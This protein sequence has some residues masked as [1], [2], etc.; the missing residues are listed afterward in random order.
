M[1]RK[2]S[3][4][5]SVLLLSMSILEGQVLTSDKDKSTSDTLKYQLEA[6]TIVATRYAESILEI[7]YAVSLINSKQLENVK[8]YGLD[9]IL[10]SVP[11]VLAQS[12]AGNQDVRLV[13]RGFGAR[14]AGDRSNSGTS[15]GLRVMLDGFP[16]TEPDGRTSFDNI[17]LSLADNIEVVRSNASALWGN[18][19]GGIININTV[20]YFE[21]SF[22]KTQ[23]T[24]GSFG[25]QKGSFQTGT[26]VG[27]GKI[28]SSFSYSSFDGWRN[29]SASKRAIAN[30]Y[31]LSDLSKNTR[32]GAYLT[33]TSNVFH[34][35][36][37]LTLKQFESEPE[38]ANST[39]EKRDERR[40]NRLG[41]IGVTFEHGFNENNQISAMAFVN[42][43]YLQR[44][45]RGT[46]RDFTRYHIGGNLLYHNNRE[47]SKE[48]TNKFSVG[49]DEAYQDGAILFYSLSST[50]GRGEISTDKRE[51]ANT[52]GA[53]VQDEV[54]LGDKL[55]IIA[56]GRLDNVTYYSEDYL[57]PEFGLQDKKFSKFTPKAGI[58]YRFNPTHSIYANL[59][60]GIEVP[61]GNETDPAGTYGQDTVYLINPL[62]DPISST[63][64][65]VG[66]KQLLMLGDDIFIKQLNYD[67][68]LYYIDIKNDI[69]PY[70]GGRFYFTA[71]KTT[72]VGAE[73]GL[74]L[75]LD[76]GLSLQT[77]FTYSQNKY[78][79]YTVDSVH[80]GKAGKIADYS[81]NKV[82]GIPDM[83]Y[84][85]QLS[86]APEFLYGISLNYSITGIGKYFVDDANETEVP[87]YTVSNISIGTSK[88]ISITNGI[89][90]KG[91]LSVNNVF[92]KKY[93]ASAF[94][95]PD[96][97]KGESV[98][99]EPGLPRNF[100]FSVSINFN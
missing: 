30:L 29:H 38:Q 64:Y 25:F 87:S 44:S 97:V 71:G 90:L 96:V 6:I 16:E 69:I 15:R 84:N 9:E 18:A 49:M 99:L 20:P 4:L 92:D 58:T 31:F 68:A 72:R 46:Y 55:S 59:G 93:A 77:A 19:S 70:R 14:G 63:T 11:G 23:Y 22:L 41:R 52:F 65:E 39:Y 56:G 81:E 95:N 75:I 13:I 28:Y 54:I 79:D 21:N 85:S 8:G 100:T 51:G 60:G 88:E 32:L 24:T 1:L 35:P 74:N 82:A 94:I 67:V 98:Y 91:F 3:L 27:N 5:L 36:G 50:N 76:H 47:F 2:F 40:Y 62:L 83:F 66:T 12:R 53:F 26:E 45:E 78:K 73:V 34:I 37:P 89:S 17:D 42:P 80:Y 57:A 7:P 61:A 10:S 48:F 86:F 43:K 33:G